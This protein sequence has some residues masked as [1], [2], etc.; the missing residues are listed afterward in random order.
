ML[1]FSRSRSILVVATLGLT[2]L[3]A[4][5]GLMTGN[6]R[7]VQAQNSD[8]SV[9]IE[10]QQS[11]VT[12]GQE[13][14]F[15]LKAS[16][17]PSSLIH[18]NV[19]VTENGSFLTGTIP[20]VITISAGEEKSYLILQTSDDAVVEDHGSVSAAVIGGAGYSVGSPASDDV[21]VKDNDPE[22]AITTTMAGTDS[23][24][25]NWTVTPNVSGQIQKIK[26]ERTDSHC[27]FF[28][29]LTCD[30]GTVNVDSFVKTPR[31]AGARQG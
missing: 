19:S 20:T 25:L 27:G 12:E 22:V 23:V 26:W 28:G 11:E 24:L 2:G 3:I 17:A 16:S 4:A 18:V 14:R 29:F 15:E 13:L 21:E 1:S 30:D 9:K 8:P 5:I 6:G 31:Q 10:R 7:T